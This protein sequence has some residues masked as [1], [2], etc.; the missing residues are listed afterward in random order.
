MMNKRRT[1]SEQMSLNR[2]AGWAKKTLE[3]RS[4]HAKMM[5]EAREAKRERTKH[6][7]SS[8]ANK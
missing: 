8:N 3:E 4:A 6:E 2:K 5:V 7:H 1:L